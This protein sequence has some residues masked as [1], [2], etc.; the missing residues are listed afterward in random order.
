M[1]ILLGIVSKYPIIIIIRLASQL[2]LH[3]TGRDYRSQ[4]IILSM[5]RILNIVQQEKLQ[6]YSMGTL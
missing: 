2:P 6:G 3:L 4:C 5:A 1:L